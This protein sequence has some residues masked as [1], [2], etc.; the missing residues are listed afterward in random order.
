MTPSFLTI[1]M[2]SAL[3]IFTALKLFDGTEMEND[4]GF[5]TWCVL[6]AQGLGAGVAYALYN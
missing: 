1:W 6:C 3:A 4:R 2:L 5:N